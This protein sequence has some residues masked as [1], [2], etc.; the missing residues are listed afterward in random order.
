[1]QKS[2]AY[3]ADRL[4]SITVDEIVRRFSSSVEIRDPKAFAAQLQT[5]LHEQ[6]EAVALPASLE[7]AVQSAALDKSLA[8]KAEALH[9]ASPWQPNE[10]DIQRGR[11]SMLE[12]FAQ[13]H[14]LPLTQFA[15]FAGKSRQ[16]IYRDI[17]AG[18]L[19]VLDIGRRGQ[20]LPDWQLDPVRLSLTQQVMQRA[21][22]VDKWTIYR[23]LSEPLEGLGGHSPINA[24]Q[25]ET[26]ED[27]T[28]TVLDVLGLH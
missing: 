7:A 1:M 9:A 24:V 8:Q 19:L 28:R 26:V 6:V 10:T 4:P 27:V 20:K 11:A 2:I 17:E 14:N 15:M 16:Q 13:A 18:R 5:F 23:A 21:P 25:P 3:I 22:S 12:E